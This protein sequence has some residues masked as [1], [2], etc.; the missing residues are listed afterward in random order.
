MPTTIDGLLVQW[1]D[2]LFYP[3]NR[4]KASRTP[5]LTDAAVRQRAQVLRQR[6][7][8]TVVQ[9][10]PQVM[11]KVTGGGRGMGAI[12]AHLRYI[13]KAG[14]LPIE[15][16]RGAVREGREALRAIA[17]QWRFGGARIPEVSERR[18]AFNTML[19]MP[20]GTDAHVMRQAAREFAKA[21]LVN[22]RYV[23]VL[24]T[25]QANP[26]VH[27]SVRAEGRDGKR[28]NPRKEDLHR[29]RETFAE[30][31]R[32]WG[33]E[34]EASSQAT[35]GVS[36]RSLR[37]WELQPSA[38]PLTGKKRGEHK[39]GRA[40]RATRSGALQAWAEIT[41]AL[42]ASPDPADRKL[43]KSIVDFVMQTEVAQAVQRHRAAQRQAELP[44]I[45]MDRGRTVQR[46]PPERSP[47][48]DLSR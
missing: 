21:E 46:V 48:P 9:R 27:I 11:V 10:A 31:L 20:A 5:V 4:M 29:W 42:A 35:R 7:R 8:A 12:A 14:R 45:N 15:D 38:Q 24:H 34:A 39:S 25:H 16:D 2:R 17:D 13:A 41:K 26:H 33:I 43:S 6:I 30:K 3:S 1:G 22:H 28:L 23:M 18:E 44:R 47:C 37:G 40:F 19:S 36:R 32:D